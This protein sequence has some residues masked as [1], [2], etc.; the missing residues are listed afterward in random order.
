MGI[1]SYNGVFI[2]TL[3][4]CIL[5]LANVLNC[6]FCWPQ[7]ARPT[8]VVNMNCKVAKETKQ[9][10]S[11]FNALQPS[12]YYLCSYT[13]YNERIV[14]ICACCISFISVNMM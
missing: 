6:V 7:M 14:C 4:G 10:E 3:F 9:M 12:S 5:L 1:I 8:A 2:R 11:L 13:C